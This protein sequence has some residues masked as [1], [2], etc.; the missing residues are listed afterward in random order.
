MSGEEYPPLNPTLQM[1]RDEMRALG[2]RV[3]DTLVEHFATLA[4]QPCMSHASRHEMDWLLQE[5]LPEHGLPVG[6]VLDR[7]EKTVLANSA[8]LNHPR[9]FSFVPGTNNFVSTMADALATGFDIFSG[10][11]VSSPGA[12]ELEIVTTNW[13]L[14]LFGLPVREG[15][16]TFV[17]GGSM[18]N[19]TGLAA[20]RKV[21]L[22]NQMDGARLYFSDQAHSSVDRA[23]LV[24]GFAPEHIRK[25][26][27]D[28]AF[29]LPMAALREAVEADL[30]AGLRPFCVV[31]N[32]GST[33][34][35]SVDPL[36]DI[37]LLCQQ[38]GL[39]MHVD[40]AY[41]GGAIMTR[42]GKGALT[43]IELADSI[44][45]DPHKWFFQPYEIG[46][47]LVRDYRWLAGTFR[48]QPEYLR[49]LSGASEEINFYDFGIQLTRRFRALKFYM[50]LKTFGLASFREAVRASLDLAEKT[51]HRLDQAPNW[52]LVTP[53]SLAIVNF[54]YRPRDV[55]LS[56][57]QLD[58]LNQAIS[59]HLIDSGHAMLATTVL[60]GRT[61]LRMCLINPLT[62]FEHVRQTLDMLETYARDEVAALQ[63]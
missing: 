40:A 59:K 19:L 18:A 15:G 13:L 22:D 26:P 28:E 3:I 31:A 52:E 42:E 60:N 58:A 47:I 30:A 63:A 35:G 48:L 7:V 16:G 46:C 27:S 33:N 20:A 51:G 8:R 23:A 11:W 41:G 34:T 57:P 1:S 44:T 21:K 9:W 61:V 10:A 25:L 45:V 12:A 24:L 56:E 17:S 5:G 14:G 2:Y 62:S 38:K 29:R 37:A 39:W 53:P 36:R 55:A 32:A 50:S 4:D 49:D 54:R 6:E 43:G